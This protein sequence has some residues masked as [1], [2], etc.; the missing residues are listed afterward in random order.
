MF[1][2]SSGPQRPPTNHPFICA[3]LEYGVSRPFNFKM[4]ISR[5]LRPLVAGAV[6]CSSIALSSSSFA[7]TEAPSPSPAGK[8]LTVVTRKV[9]PFVFEKNGQLTG[10]SIELWERIVREARLPFDPDS[11]Y[12]QVENVQQMLDELRGG[13]ADAGVAAVSITSEREKTIDFS[14]PFKE[15]GLQILTRDQPGSSFGKIVGNLFKGDIIWLLGG[16]FVVLLLNSHIIW[17]LERK[18]NPESFPEGYI[19]GLWEAIWWSLCTII[20]GGCENKA[21][22]GVAGRLTAIVWMLAGAGLFTY[23]TATI[24]SAMTVETL[25][26][27]IQNVADLKAHKWMVGTV[28]G[29]TA[30]TFLERQGVSVQGF[31][32]VDAACNALAD[33]KVKAVIY[34]APMLLYFAKNNPDKKLGVVGELFEKQAY[35]IGVPQGSP[36][37]KEITRSILAL[38]E[39][40]FFDELESKYFGTVTGASAS[41]SH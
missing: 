1:T 39:Q 29:S 8:K 36:Y 13:R 20:T 11:G 7:Q 33:D 6:L 34:D 14:Y 41:A 18:K 32:D 15:S 5:L 24:T 21:P 19:A 40:G 2:A 3:S 35:G 26:S 9:T 10:Y 23:I 4:I 12:K 17:F 22:L 27:D 31:N 16:L 37:R 28:A 25:N 38:R 30:L